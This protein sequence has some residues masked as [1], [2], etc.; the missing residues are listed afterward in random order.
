[1][2]LGCQPDSELRLANRKEN[3]STMQSIQEFP[4]SPISVTLLHTADLLAAMSTYTL[5]TAKLALMR[6]E[7]GDVRN[8]VEKAIHGGNIVSQGMVP[9]QSERSS[10]FGKLCTSQE[11]SDYLRKS[12]EDVSICE[13]VKDDDVTDRLMHINFDRAVLRETLLLRTYDPFIGQN[14]NYI[15][16]QTS[17]NCT[18][19]VPIY[20]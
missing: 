6:N 1:M 7:V 5:L 3:N 16:I 8:A 17:D 4:S 9:I 12:E 11:C 20:F 2:V 15:N 13:K 18:L 10:G 19:Y 14:C